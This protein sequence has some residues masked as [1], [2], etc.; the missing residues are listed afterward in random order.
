MMKTFLSTGNAEQRKK[1]LTLFLTEKKIMKD[2]TKSILRE[3]LLD[4]EA[5][6]GLLCLRSMKSI[7]NKI[8]RS[9]A[10]RIS[11]KRRIIVNTLLA[12][13]L[14]EDNCALSKSKMGKH[15]TVR[16]KNVLNADILLSSVSEENPLP[17]LH[18]SVRDQV[19]PL[20]P[21]KLLWRDHDFMME[22]IERRELLNA[23]EDIDGD[24]T[25][26]DS[27]GDDDEDEDSVDD[28]DDDTDE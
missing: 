5:I 7:F 12:C 25:S 9:R 26:V 27:D 14:N 16:M 24:K 15:A 3:V 21:Q 23:K 2:T 4:E 22:E 1:T 8:L 28:A 20:H 6:A 18:P 13:I 11:V 17:R 19:L 10:G